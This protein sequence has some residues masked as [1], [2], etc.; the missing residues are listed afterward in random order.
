MS[1]KFKPGDKVVIKNFSKG[2]STHRGW[3]IGDSFIVSYI[4]GGQLVCPKDLKD[5]QYS[6]YFEEVELEEIYHSPLYQ[7]LL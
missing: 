1:S 5:N 7:A 4:F 6:P 3:E 2:T